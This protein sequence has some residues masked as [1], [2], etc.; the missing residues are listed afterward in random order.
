MTLKAPAF[1][2]RPSGAAPRPWLLWPAAR[3]WGAAS[4]RRMARPPHYRPPVPGHLRRQFRRRRRRQDA[5]RDRPCP[6]RPRSRAEGPGLLAVRLWRPRDG[7]AARRSRLCTMPTGWATRRCCSPLPARRSSPA[8]APPAPARLV[9]EGV[10]IIIMD[11]GFQNPSLAKDLSLVVV[12]A[13]GRYRQRLASCPPARCARRLTLQLRSRR[14]ARSS[15]ARA[16]RPSR[17]SEPAARAGRAALARHLRPAKTR[18]WR[19]QPIL[20]FAGIGRPEKFFATLGRRCMPRSSAP[21]AFP[22]TI[23]ITEAEA[24][25]LLAAAEAGKLQAGDDRKGP[26]PPRRRDRRS[27]RHCATRRRLSR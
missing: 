8:T 12:D 7:A 25:E 14:R 27:R 18:G 5:D 16:P 17:W 26:R 10:D 15:S 19:K 23:A 13:D 1:W 11:D 24:A 6:H 2:W 3:L 4:A 21:S 9:E 20:A 22:T